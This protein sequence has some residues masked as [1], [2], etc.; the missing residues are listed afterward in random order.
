MAADW[1]L[2]QSPAPGSTARFIAW[3]EPTGPDRGE[4]PQRTLEEVAPAALGCTDGLQRGWTQ[5]RNG[6]GHPS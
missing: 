5:R 4:T 3:R 6:R 1:L 2:R